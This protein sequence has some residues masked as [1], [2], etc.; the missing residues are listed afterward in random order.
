MLM[1]VNL[2]RQKYTLAKGLNETLMK[3]HNYDPVL[4]RPNI[5]SLLVNLV[6]FPIKLA[7]A[8]LCNLD[9]IQN[10][11]ETLRRRL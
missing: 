6:S 5:F 9:R 3:K 11:R 7:L 2:I 1:Q 4:I 8:F 10:I